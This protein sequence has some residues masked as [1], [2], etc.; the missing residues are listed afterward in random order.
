M[1]TN[2]LENIVA[3][4]ADQRTPT[5]RQVLLRLFPEQAGILRDLFDL[6]DLLA[7]F[8]QAQ[9]RQPSPAFRARLKSELLAEME[10]REETQTAQQH[11]PSP[12]SR[13]DHRR[14]LAAVGVGSAAVAVAA[15]ALVYWHSRHTRLAA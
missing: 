6:T 9:R 5:H 11:S 13:S 7:E 3:A 14:Y 15:G 12:P 8:F 2:W 1:T 4:Y 10:K